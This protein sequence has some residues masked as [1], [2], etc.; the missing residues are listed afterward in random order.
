M[1]ENGAN[2]EAKGGTHGN[3]LAAASIKGRMEVVQILLEKGA[4]VEAESGLALRKASK[5]GREAV[6]R[7][8]LEHKAD[9]NLA[10]QHDSESLRGISIDDHEVVIQLLLEKL[11]T[12]KVG[13]I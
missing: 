7:L 12:L 8:L 11:E 5:K 4:D 13:S 2:V 9:D 1:L 6:M 3:A 10:F